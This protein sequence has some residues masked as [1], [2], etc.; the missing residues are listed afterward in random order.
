MKSQTSKRSIWIKG[1]ILIPLTTLLLLSFSAREIRYTKVAQHTSET[2]K[3]NTEFAKTPFLLED[4][5]FREPLGEQQE[6]SEAQL[7]KYNDLAKKYNKQPI[8]TRSIPLIDLKTLESIYKKM[9][10]AQKE[11]AVAFPECPPKKKVSQDGAPRKLMAE[12]NKLAKHYNSMPREH[13]QISLKDVKR[14]KYIYGLMS[15]KQRADAEPF[16]DFPPMP[17]PPPPAVV[18]QL[19]SA[20]EVAPSE[21][22]APSPAIASQA[23]KATKATLAVVPPSSPSAEVAVKPSLANV[24]PPPPPPPTPN[25]LD[26]VIK[27][28]K[29]DA[30]FYYQNKKISSD[31]AI[32]IIK[33]NN[34]LSISVKRKNNNPP[35]VKIS[36]YL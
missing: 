3:T 21:A 30:I 19:A 4:V 6:V 5:T 23:I 29:E 18:P 28:T 20:S 26:E 15:E 13:M 8:E 9:S 32:S 27:L 17:D 34:D 14:L 10:S 1:V 31:K 24:P 35:V 25:P 22:L 33:Q 12:Y 16:P 2:D 36:K 7:R 11:R